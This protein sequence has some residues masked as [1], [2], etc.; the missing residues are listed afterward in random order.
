MWHVLLNLLLLLLQTV[1][2]LFSSSFKFYFYFLFSVWQLVKKQK[3]Y[4]GNI[5]EEF[6]K[7]V[8]EVQQIYIILPSTP[9]IESSGFTK[10]PIPIH[11]D[12]L[13][14]KQRI[15]VVVFGCI[16]LYM[17]DILKKKNRSSNPKKLKKH[18][19]VKNECIS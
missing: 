11:I 1:P 15:Y 19:L 13:V 5:P 17:M 14:Y 2:K 4:F 10:I 7:W 18:V 9:N 16:M 6:L 8:L 3:K 12:Y